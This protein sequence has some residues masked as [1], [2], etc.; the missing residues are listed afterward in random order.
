M[1]QTKFLQALH[2]TDHCNLKTFAKI[3]VVIC[4]SEKVNKDYFN[5][6]CFDYAV[7]INKSKPRMSEK[8]NSA[9][10][11]TDSLTHFIVSENLQ[12]TRLPQKMYQSLSQA[13]LRFEILLNFILIYLS[14]INQLSSA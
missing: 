4:Y 10:M 8:E 14:S 5:Y 3:S 6:I 13:L 11:S 1:K 7:K 12:P 2:S 9:L